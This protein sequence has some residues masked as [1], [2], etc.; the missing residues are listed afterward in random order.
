MK[1]KVKMRFLTKIINFFTGRISDEEVATTEWVLCPKCNVNI[2]K[3]DFVAN[4][5]KCPLC[6]SI[7]EIEN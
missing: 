4:D 2:A 6:N 7:I 5:C 1:K 3:T